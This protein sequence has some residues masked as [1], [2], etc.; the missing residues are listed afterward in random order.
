MKVKAKIKIF[1]LAIMGAFLFLVGNANAFKIEKYDDKIE[2]R[3]IVSPGKIDQKLNPGDF[4]K[5]DITVVNRLGKQQEFFV[6]REVINSGNNSVLIDSA[7]EWIVPEVETFLLDHGG[8]INFEVAINVPSDTVSSGYYFSIIIGTKGEKSSGNDQVELISQIGLPVFI[9]VEGKSLEKKGGISNFNSNHFLY[10]NGPI[11]FSAIV[12]NRGNVHLQPFGEISVYNLIGSKVAQLPL[13]PWIVLPNSKAGQSTVWDEKWLMGRY[14]AD[15]KIFINENQI[16][17]NS[18]VFYAFPLHIL[19]LVIFII[20]ILYCLIKY[21]HSKYE[22]R[23][24]S[25]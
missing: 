23:L 25:K 21:L 3:F 4:R 2:G 16:L 11:E 17:E 18:Y 10:S 6:N 14:R 5:V 20:V 19:S 22:I 9:T 13:K 7:K 1:L 8:R 15:L 12:E 24:N